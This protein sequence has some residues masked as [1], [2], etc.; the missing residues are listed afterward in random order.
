MDA[1][2]QYANLARAD[3]RDANLSGDINM[4]FA[5]LFLTRFEGQDLS[6]VT[7]IE[8]SQLDLSCGDSTTILPAGLS[9]SADWPCDDE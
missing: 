3:F 9:P 2:F 4:A 6:T 7:G 8:Q 1:V 5:Y